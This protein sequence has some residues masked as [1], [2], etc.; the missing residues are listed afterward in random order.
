MAIPFVVDLP[1]TIYVSQGTFDL[2]RRMTCNPVERSDMQA[3][4]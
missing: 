3:R 4:Y 2:D 1:L